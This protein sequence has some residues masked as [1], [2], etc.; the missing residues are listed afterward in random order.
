MT[1]L[2]E[3]LACSFCGEDIRPDEDYHQPHEGRCPNSTFHESDD[4]EWFDGCTCD[5]YKCEKCV[6]A[7]RDYPYCEQCGLPILEDDWRRLPGGN[8]IHEGCDYGR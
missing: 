7:E 8:P 5:L 4:Q 1:L 3:R 6:D 2:L